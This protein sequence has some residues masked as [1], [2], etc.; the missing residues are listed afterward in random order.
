MKWTITEKGFGFINHI[1]SIE[2]YY[3]NVTGLRIEQISRESIVFKTKRFFPV[4][5]FNELAGGLIK[6]LKE[7][8]DGEL[9]T[10]PDNGL[11]VDT[12]V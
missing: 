8:R 7:E 9:C 12:G 6:K 10:A 3:A 11:G 1:R 4:K 5:R 2:A